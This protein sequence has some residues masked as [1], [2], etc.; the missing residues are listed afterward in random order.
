MKKKI[1]AALAL[2]VMTTPVLALADQQN[3]KQTT[4]DEVVVTATKTVEK[5]RDVPNAVI[6]KD[7]L[8][9]EDSPGQG[10]GELLANEPG[11][12][13]RTY[14][15]YGGAAQTI[16]IRGMG[17]QATQVF[18][19]GINL[20]SPSL[21]SADIGRLPIN[22]IE[23]IE[24]VKGGG[25]VLY[26]TGAMGGTVHLV[27]KDPE[28]DQMIAKAKVGYGSQQSYEL[29][30]EHGM[31]VAD[32]LG[33]YLT[34][35][36]KE[37]DGFRDNS[38]L[39]H[40]DLSMK[41]LFDMP[42]KIHVS[43]FTTY[44]DR[45]NGVPGVKPPEGT[46]A[47]SINGTVLYNDQAASLVNKGESEDW[48]NVLEFKAHASD[49]VDLTMRTDYSDMQRYSLTRYNSSGTGVETWISNKN[50]G[51]EG[52]VDWHPVKPL[53]V[54]AGGQ[55]RDYDSENEQGTID[56]F[57]GSVAGSR[58]TVESSVF[59]HAAY[60][61]AQY[62]PST[63][64]KI[65]AGVRNENHSTAG[66]DVVPRLGLVV[67]PFV[68]TA[69][70]L[71]HGKHFRAP[72]INDLF[73]PDTGFAKGNTA[74]V[75]ESGWHSD[76]SL[77]Q[78][79][80]HDKVMLTLSYF[81]TDIDDKIAWAEDP[82]DPNVIG[83]GG[84]WK[85]SNVNKFESKGLEFGFTIKPTDPLRIALS[86]TYLDAREEKVAGAWRQATN[87]ADNTF[88]ADVGYLFSFGLYGS[89]VVRYVD[90]RPSAYANDSA[91]TP[92]HVLDSYWTA[93]IKLSQSLADHW[94]FTLTTLNIFDEE[95]DTN[96]SDFYG[97]SFPSTA[98]CGYPGVGR[99]FFV[100][101]GYEF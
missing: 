50:T 65:L 75:A 62:R 30:A 31:F 98:N 54:L 53:T 93:D 101:V 27:S 10:I 32:N 69:I 44:I 79:L 83:F 82:S 36:R 24:V 71:S 3:D 80:W 23:K 85:P 16:N 45:E 28:R 8:D 74:L 72:T 41:L 15:N 57:G 77:D 25:S 91:L 42:E 11:I 63:Y 26:G 13:W 61:E 47:H 12:D 94:L 38:D 49:F 20:N 70:K 37:T 1:Q 92:E 48:H 55:Y 22:G 88:K 51:L 34:A 7:A 4:L 14:G 67:N 6:V 56:A 9:L 90:E 17:S 66:S 99:S 18:L 100:S 87:T 73:W 97:A 60:A 89:M 43:F 84:Y 58:S 2:F 76:I 29:S 5:R 39:E 95:Y 81:Q 86:Y 78:S 19:N 33:Y 21:G 59:S 64:V 35:T 96:S 68:T 46:A 52:F 40:N